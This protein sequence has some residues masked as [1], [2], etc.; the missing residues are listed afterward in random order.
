MKIKTKLLVLTGVVVI[1]LAVLVGGMYFRTSQV[2]GNLADA[3]AMQAVAYLND[4]VDIYMRGLENICDSA[5]PVITR[6]FD[7]NGDV[8]KEE[9]LRALMEMSD[10]TKEKGV[11]HIYVGLEKEGFL[12]SGKGWVPPSDF[13]VRTRPWYRDAAAAKRTALTQPYVDADVGEMVLSICAPI[14]SP[15]KRVLGVFAADIL[16]EEITSKIRDAKIFGAG[17]GI[18]LAPDGL[19]LEHPD[20]SFISVENLSKASERVHEDLVNLGRKMITREAGFGDYEL[21]GTERRIYYASGS[22][23]YIAALVFPRAQ[24][25]AVVRSVTMT[26]IVTGAIAIVLI[27]IYMF[28][29][30]PSVTKPLHAVVMTLNRIAELDMTPNPMAVKVVANLNPKTELGAMVEAARNLRETFIDI[31]SSV[32]EGVERLASSSCALDGLSKGV[33][34]DV[35]SSKNAAANVEQLANE[36]LKSVAAA[37]EAVQEVTHAA[38]MT[39]TSAVGGAEASD[40]TSKL[41]SRVSDMMNAFVSELQSVG[42]ASAENRR[43]MTEVGASVTAIGT[44]VT[45]IRNIASQTNLLALNAAIEAARAGDAGRGFSVVADEVRKLAEESNVASRHVGEMMEKLEIGTNNA[46]DSAQQSADTIT[47]IVARARETRESLENANAEIDKVND[48]VQTI[49][50]AAQEQVAS[51]NEIAESS[52][53]ARDSIGDVAREVSAITRAAAE[54]QDAIQKVSDEAVNLLSISANLE[55]LMARFTIE[56][57]AL[58]S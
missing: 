16:L 23:G 9:L 43:G 31:I 44:F 11:L 8:D 40:A 17:Y 5:T 57:K 10:R 15:D 14:L 2:T 6:M 52:S 42:D 12:I 3:D 46:I 13:D 22:A 26:Q 1:V 48:A 39:A 25:V 29:M 49:A 56:S 54:T 45:S 7:E 27:T 47:R 4:T 19:V 30:I 36:A 32:N 28:I 33:A 53:R 21:L 50:A 35:D 34:A 55:G 37:A 20:K 24:S 51:S 18:L 38:T 58:K 41:S